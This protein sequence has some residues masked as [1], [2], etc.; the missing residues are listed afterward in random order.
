[1]K[2]GAEFSIR[3]PPDLANGFPSRISSELAKFAEFG[4]KSN[5]L[6]AQ[7]N[8]FFVYLKKKNHENLKRKTSLRIPSKLHSDDL[9]GNLPIPR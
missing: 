4:A 2:N 7:T 3:I 1:M 5:V 6:N 8:D 9:S